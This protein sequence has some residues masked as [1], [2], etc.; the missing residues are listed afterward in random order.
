[1]YYVY[2]LFCSDSCTYIGST[3]DLKDR[4]K[5]HQSGYIPATQKRLPVKLI[6]Y[7][8]FSKNQLHAILKNTLSPDQQS[9]LKKHNIISL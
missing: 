6:N 1:M 8:A 3:N 9:I 2:I 5:R 4:I 7:F